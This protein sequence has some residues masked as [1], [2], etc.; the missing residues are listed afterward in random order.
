MA[1]NFNDKDLVISLNCFY[2]V[3]K[4]DVILVDIPKIGIVIKRVEF[5]ENNVLKIT[6]DNHEYTTNIYDDAFNIES[7]KGKV[8][9]K[10]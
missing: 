6:G 8:I 4:G 9:F 5:I 1:P 10:F 7:V 2:L 3:K